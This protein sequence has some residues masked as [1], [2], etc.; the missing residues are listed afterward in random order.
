MEPQFAL[1]HALAHSP[2][3]SVPRVMIHADISFLRIL[4]SL[5]S[6]V[7]CYILFLMI[8]A[9]TI[10]MYDTCQPSLEHT[11]PSRHSVKTYQVYILWSKQQRLNYTHNGLLL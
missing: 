7:Q 1:V 4:V 11:N 3:H 10:A 9:I 5:S 2:S 8:T 6:T